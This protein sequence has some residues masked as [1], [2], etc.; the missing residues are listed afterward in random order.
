MKWEMKSNPDFTA[1]KVTFDGPNEQ[2]VL[3]ADAMVAMD[4]S[5]QMK[6]GARGGLL[7]A[8]TRMLAGESLFQNT[9]TSTRPGETLWLAPALDG[10]IHC[11]MIS[12]S[13]A[14]NLSSTCFV[15]SAPSVV[16]DTKFAGFK[17][18]FSGRGVFTVRCTGE[19]PLWFN[20]YGA[21]HRVD[22]APGE[23]YVV[24]NHHIA[25]FTDG[26][27]HEVT[28][29]GGIG[30]FLVGGEGLVCK[31]RGPGTVWIQTRTPGGLAAFLF[32]FRPVKSND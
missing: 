23:A 8:A 32:P 12:S 11:E 21:L 1:C 24:D 29:I 6:T 31:F 7:K 26:M 16:L 15:A 4:T 17:G 20:G 2:V 28:K 10:D 13:H 18:F 25:A 14:I 22:L 9:F 3:E 27:A 5:V 30:S 19:G